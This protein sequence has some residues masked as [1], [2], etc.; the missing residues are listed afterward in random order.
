MRIAFLPNKPERADIRT[1]RVQVFSSLKYTWT[2]IVD[3]KNI[4]LFFEQAAI[5]VF[6]K[7]F[8]QPNLSVLFFH[9]SQKF[10]RKIAEFGLRKDYK[11][12]QK[13]TL[14]LKMF[15]SRAFKKGEKIEISDDK[16][17]EEVETSKRLHF[18]T[19]AYKVYELETD[20]QFFRTMANL[21]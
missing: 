17:L 7:H 20:L 10:M 2:L 9:L 1:H 4:L 6:Q 13:F 18:T 19:I 14:A 11:T 3:P 21:S 8:S 12:N 15:S 16:R 5:Q